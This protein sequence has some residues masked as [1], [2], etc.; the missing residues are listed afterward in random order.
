MPNLVDNA[1][2]GYDSMELLE[3]E[4]GEILSCSNK[5]VWKREIA[6]LRDESIELPNGDFSPS[7]MVRMISSGIPSFTSSDSIK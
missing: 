1:N 7:T 3:C 4:V 6:N 5:L 2:L